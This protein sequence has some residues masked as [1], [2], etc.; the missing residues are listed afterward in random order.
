[1]RRCSD[2]HRMFSVTIIKLPTRVSDWNVRDGNCSLAFNE[3]K[4]VHGAKKACPE[5]M[6]SHI[7]SAGRADSLEIEKK[8]DGW[9]SVSPEVAKVAGLFILCK[10]APSSPLEIVDF[11]K[12]ILHTCPPRRFTFLP[13]HF[14]V[15]CSRT[16]FFTSACS[17]I[18]HSLR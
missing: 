12:A 2:E 18:S 11:S 17:C 6:I 13:R 15:S 16:S 5:R 7:I 14:F 8:S 10:R 3:S 4:G 1:M 9:K